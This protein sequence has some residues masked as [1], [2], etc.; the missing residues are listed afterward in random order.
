MDEVSGES[1]SVCTSFIPFQVVRLNRITI[2]LGVIVAVAL[3]APW[4]TTA[5]FLV[6]ALAAAFGRRA[7]LIYAIGS[8]VFREPRG[9][10]AS[11]KLRSRSVRRSWGGYSPGSRRLP[12]RSRSAASVSAAS[13][14]ISSS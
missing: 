7:S 11:P 14:F 5:L 13:C 12:Q 6:V 9:F 3:R 8:R 4:I 1:L 10:S 2:L